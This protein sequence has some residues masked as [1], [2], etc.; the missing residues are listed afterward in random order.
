MSE[1][2]EKE[3]VN[4]NAEEKGNKL[5]LVELSGL[6]GNN[7]LTRAGNDQ[8]VDFRKNAEAATNVFNYVRLGENAILAGM[9]G[10]RGELP[11]AIERQMLNV[12]RL[13]TSELPTEVRVGTAAH[14][15]RLADLSA[16]E[17]ALTRKIGGRG[18][19]KGLAT[20]G[21]V[22]AAEKYVDSQ[23]FEDEPIRGATF[24]ADMVA[25]PAIAFL[26]GS[27]ALKGAAMFGTHMLG[28]YIDKKYGS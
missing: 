25:S 9:A 18:M 24:V 27:W 5:N 13:V 11:T 15:K 12:N 16:E 22:W 4:Q 7:V 20:I 14:A 6:N 23:L 17:A 21:V 26:P 28:R 1:K 2:F 8:E 19:F 10:F 3:Q